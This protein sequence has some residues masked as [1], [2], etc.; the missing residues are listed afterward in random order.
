FL[1]RAAGQDPGEGLTFAVAGGSDLS[2]VGLLRGA[3]GYEGLGREPG[4]GQNLSRNGF[5]IEFDTL[6]GSGD[7]E[8]TGSPD[9]PRPLHV[10]IDAMNNVNTVVQTSGGLPDPFA[11]AGVHVTVVYNRGQLGVYLAPNGVE[12]AAP[13]KA[14]EASVLPISFAA[15]EEVAVFG[16]TA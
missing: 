15:L 7:N 2:R 1:A 5:A 12:G 11:P 14:L 10:G 3:L 4:T 8:G 9:A 13:V 6:K 16:F